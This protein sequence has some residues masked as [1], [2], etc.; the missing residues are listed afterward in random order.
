MTNTYAISVFIRILST[1]HY[2]S[3][4][5]SNYDKNN[6][7]ISINQICKIIGVSTSQIDKLISVWE[8]LGIAKEFKYTNNKRYLTISEK[9]IANIYKGK[10]L[11]KKLIE[12]VN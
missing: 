8:S 12:N 4:I 1:F 10:E 5:I 7:F 6:S 11:K 9:I 3:G 2:E